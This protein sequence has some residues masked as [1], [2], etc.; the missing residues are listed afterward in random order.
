[1]FWC[2]HWEIMYKEDFQKVTINIKKKI[3]S[4]Y[5]SHQNKHLL[6]LFFHEHFE[7]FINL[8]FWS[9]F[10][11]FCLNLGWSTTHYRAESSLYILRKSSLSEMCTVN[12][13]PACELI[14]ILI[15]VSLEE[16]FGIWVEHSLWFFVDI[17]FWCII[18]KKH[19]LPFQKNEKRILMV[20]WSFG[21]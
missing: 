20:S 16:H 21:F 4:F 14:F 7:I 6:D 18:F 11:S 5:F 12:I 17:L 10:R 2:K 1:M 15:T 9:L 8:L 3:H 13:F 19:L